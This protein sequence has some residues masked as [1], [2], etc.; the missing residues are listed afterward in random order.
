[1]RTKQETIELAAK[2]EARGFGCAPL[3]GDIEQK[4][5]ERTVARLK[6]GDLDILVAT[7]VAARGL[8]VDRISHVVNYDV[9]TDSESYVHRIGRTGRAGRSGEAILFVAPR[10]RHMLQIIERATRQSIALMELPSAAAINDQRLGK[11][12]ER[13]AGV[14]GSAHAKKDLQQF[15]ALIEQFQKEQGAELLDIA[16][17]LAHIGQGDTP[18]LS[19]VPPPRARPEGRAERHRPESR[20]ERAAAAG[21]PPRRSAN[22]G[23]A[24]EDGME[25]Y[26]IEVGHQHG[27][28][29]GNIVGAIANEA[30]LDSQHIGRIRILDD[31]SLVDLP[32]GMPKETLHALRNVWV[33]SQKMRISKLGSTP[34]PA[35]K[36]KSHPH[37]HR[38]GKP[39]DRGGR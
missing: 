37:T 9:P 25:T 29:P 2:L 35:V 23:D 28:K 34:P 22:R 19:E 26:R 11:L 36:P 21:E 27:V 8:D 17:A 33:V 24:P 38:H 6:S 20:P 15:R 12:K 10:E 13:I 1:V 18:L 16:A 32:A 30:D 39:K 3:N 4:V 5:R 14:L 7:D 31:H